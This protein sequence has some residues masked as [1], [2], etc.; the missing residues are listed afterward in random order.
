MWLIFVNGN[1]VGQQW[2]R[3]NPNID[4]GLIVLFSLPYS[5]II[6]LNFIFNKEQKWINIGELWFQIKNK[7]WLTSK[8][9]GVKWPLSSI[10]YVMCSV[11]FVAT[12]GPLSWNGC[13]FFLRIFRGINFVEFTMKYQPKKQTLLYHNYIQVH[14]CGI[15]GRCFVLKFSLCIAYF[16]V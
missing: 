13:V 12:E 5:C 7:I 10:N 8:N 3:F 11:F 6:I 16:K 15:Y 2:Y 14:I 9:M 1:N 4:W